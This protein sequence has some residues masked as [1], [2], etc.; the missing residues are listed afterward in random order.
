MLCRLN[1]MNLLI[2]LQH[3]ASMP[4]LLQLLATVQML[5]GICL[6]RSEQISCAAQAEYNGGSHELAL[7]CKHA[8]AASA[9]VYRSG[10]FWHMLATQREEGSEHD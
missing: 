3:S 5:S 10:V 1:T 8:S 2:N 7:Q 6:P 9:A 4:A